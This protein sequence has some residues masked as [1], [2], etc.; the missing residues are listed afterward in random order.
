L[1]NYSE[2]L[3]VEKAKDFF[4]NTVIPFCAERKIE[5]SFTNFF[6]YKSD[7]SN[8]LIDSVGYV[9]ANKVS[10]YI[11]YSSKSFC[12]FIESLEEDFVREILPNFHPLDI[13][14]FRLEIHNSPYL[15]KMLME[16]MKEDFQKFTW[17]NN[18]L[19]NNF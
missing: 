19:Q 15:R 1:K 3:I 12:K 14:N 5:E 13:M 17:K 8:I 18:V 7:S 9:R 4:T 10:P 6:S 2:L 11:L 16:I